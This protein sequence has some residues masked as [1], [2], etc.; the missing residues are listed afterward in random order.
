[1]SKLIK[2]HSCEKH[3][4]KKRKTKNETCIQPKITEKERKKKEENIKKLVYCC[5]FFFV[6]TILQQQK[7]KMISISKEKK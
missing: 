1:M 5:C 2:N 4:T 6:E 3:E 7:P